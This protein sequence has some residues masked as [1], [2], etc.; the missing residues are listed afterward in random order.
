[1]TQGGRRCKAAAYGTQRQTLALKGGAQNGRRLTLALKGGAQNGRRRAEPRE[2][3]ERETAGGT[4][5]RNRE[6]R[7][8]DVTD[9]LGQT[10]KGAEQRK[11]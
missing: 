7:G 5:G 8:N 4:A 6:Q 2:R 9:S 11:R 3:T 1:M 10:R